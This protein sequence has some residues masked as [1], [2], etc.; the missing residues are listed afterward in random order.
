MTKYWVNTNQPVI[1]KAFMKFAHNTFSKYKG[2]DAYE[3][4]AEIDDKGRLAYVYEVSNHYQSSWT[5]RNEMTHE[6][7]CNY[8]ELDRV[9]RFYVG[10]VVPKLKKEH[11]AVISQLVKSAMTT[12]HHK[13]KC[14]WYN[15]YGFDSKA[16][17]LTQ[18]TEI[19]VAYLKEHS[20]YREKT[21]YVAKSTLAV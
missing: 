5:G 19:V 4:Y 13:N 10:L 1:T 7:M 20:M 3:T 18:I 9:V 8:E 2:C 11:V 21:E 16:I 17:E 14:D 12:Q 6:S 15:T